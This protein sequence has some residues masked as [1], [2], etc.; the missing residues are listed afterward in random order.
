MARGRFLPKSL[1]TDLRTTEVDDRALLLYVLLL[2]H[3]D[4]DGRISGHPRVVRATVLPLREG[5]TDPD[6]E[7]AL[8][9]LH[10]A[11]LIE[12]YAVDGERFVQYP[13]WKK[14]QSGLR[15]DREAQSEIPPP[16]GVFQGVSPGVLREFARRAPR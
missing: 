7:A 13:G 5:W 9:E 11:K 2:P 6:V 15:S 8:N 10:E 1:A 12:L 3:A 4:V 16:P 14:M